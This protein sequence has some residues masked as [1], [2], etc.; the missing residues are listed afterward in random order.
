MSIPVTDYTFIGD[1]YGFIPVNIL[2]QME[3]MVLAQASQSQQL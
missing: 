3:L 2:M 1:T